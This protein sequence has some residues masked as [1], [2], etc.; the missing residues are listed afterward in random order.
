MRRRP[1]MLGGARLSCALGIEVGA[2]ACTPYAHCQ[3]ARPCL[4]APPCRSPRGHPHPWGNPPTSTGSASPLQSASPPPITG[5]LAARLEAAG[6]AL[7][8]MLVQ[9]PELLMHLVH[10]PGALAR[11]VQVVGR[12]VREVADH[13]PWAYP[14]IA[15]ILSHLSAILAHVVCR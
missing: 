15:S 6:G 7:Y 13:G 3:P 2:T 9:T 11:V 4:P 1:C 5:P 8:L 12:L 10:V 14:T